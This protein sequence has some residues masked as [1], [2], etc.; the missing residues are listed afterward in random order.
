MYCLLCSPLLSSAIYLFLLSFCTSLLSSVCLMC[1]AGLSTLPTPEAASSLGI[2]SVEDIL[3]KHLPA[4]VEREEVFRIL[5]GQRQLLQTDITNNVL[6]H[7][8]KLDFDVRAES[9]VQADHTLYG[10]RQIVRVGVIQNAI[11]NPTTDTVERQFQGIVSRVE[12]IIDAAGMSG[13]QVLA[14][15]EAWT[16]PFAFCTREKKPWMEFA[17]DAEE[18]RSSEFIKRKAKQWKMVIVSPILERD[19]QHMGVVWNTAV[20][21][22]HKGTVLGKHRKNHIPRTGDFNESTYYLEGNTGH[23]VFETA[24]GRIAVNICY[25]RHHPLNWMGFALNGAQIVFNPS[26]TIDGL[27]E[28][29]WGIEARNAAVANGYFVAAVNR[30]GTESFPNEFTSADGKPA[31]TNFGHFY[32]SSYVSA[33]DGRRT[34]SLSRGRDGLLIVDIDLKDIEET[35]DRWMF[36][37]TMRPQMYAKLL[38]EYSSHS[39][40]PQ[41]ITGAGGDSVPHHHHHHHQRGN[42]HTTV[43]GEEGNACGV[44]AAN[45]WKDDDA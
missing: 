31:H 42:H 27:S 45:L 20:I 22:D 36:N 18:G 26:A 24:Y 32:G 21:V 30:V 4:G 14:L 7:A 44:P 15:Q 25:G 16:M 39:F 9:L 41:V 19:Q 2:S 37:A 13:V 5:Y 17:E 40:Q 29:L 34:G 3:N 23:P 6:L 1:D 38:S 28:P 35:R 11:T 8:K 33:P 12:D 10:G 43:R